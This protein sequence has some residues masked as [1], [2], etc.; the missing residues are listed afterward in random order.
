MTIWDLV[1]FY[2]FFSIIVR[3]VWIVKTGFCCSSKWFGPEKD[4]LGSEAPDEH[5][6][7]LRCRWDILLVKDMRNQC[8]AINVTVKD[9]A[10]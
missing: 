6:S 8:T 5:T 4:A 10:V 1:D 7:I 2:I 3:V 9:R